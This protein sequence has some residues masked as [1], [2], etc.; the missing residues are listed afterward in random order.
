MNILHINSSQHDKIFV[1]IN[2]KKYESEAR[3]GASQKLLPLID[4]ALKDN[5]IVYEDLTEINVEISGESFTGIRVGVAIANTL[6][7]VLK[8][9]VNGSTAPVNPHY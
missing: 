1:Q 6:G 7:W 4:S 5:N 3:N 2:D 8:I 9:P